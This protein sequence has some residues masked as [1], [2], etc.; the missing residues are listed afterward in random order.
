[1]SNYYSM[2]EEYG[3]EKDT[4]TILG[5]D[6]EFALSMLESRRNSLKASLKG[7][8]ETKGINRYDYEKDG[9]KVTLSLVVDTDGELKEVAERI[10]ERTE[11]KE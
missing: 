7:W 1:M 11:T 10:L 4:L 6:R 9:K 2:K 8:K 5:E 3:N